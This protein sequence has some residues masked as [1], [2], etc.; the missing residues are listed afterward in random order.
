[1]IFF[2]NKKIEIWQLEKTNT[3]DKYSDEYKKEYQLKDT[4]NVDF[5][6]LSVAE[7]MKEF[8]EILQDTYKI[9]TEHNIPNT[10]I[11]RIKG[12]KDTYEIKGSKQKNNHF[13]Q[14]A[15]NKLIL[16]KEQK[17]RKLGK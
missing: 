5:Q 8:G 11:L 10:A 1:M 15:H 16:I 6:N 7:N 13:K 17:P 14:T 3:Y 2:K 12:E 9:Y 4:I